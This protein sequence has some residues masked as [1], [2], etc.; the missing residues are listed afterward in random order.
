LMKCNC[1]VIFGVFW[2]EYRG[3]QDRGSEA[4]ENPHVNIYI[5][6]EAIRLC[7]LECSSKYLGCDIPNP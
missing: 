7:L 4:T 6:I 3:S 5:K 1:M 2:S